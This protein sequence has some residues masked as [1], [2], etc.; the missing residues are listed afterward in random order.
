[1]E[2][3]QITT[4]NLSKL[5]VFV[6]LCHV[7]TENFIAD[8]YVSLDKDCRHIAYEC[9]EHEIHLP[10]RDLNSDLLPNSWNEEALVRFTISVETQKQVGYQRKA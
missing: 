4:I 9:D 6:P 3:P 2:S 8:S 1:M 10:P 5:V 7:S